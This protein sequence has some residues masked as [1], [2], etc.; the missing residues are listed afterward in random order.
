MFVHYFNH[1]LIQTLAKNNQYGCKSESQVE[2][3]ISAIVQIR[4]FPYYQKIIK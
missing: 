4:Y 2:M 3:D 1:F